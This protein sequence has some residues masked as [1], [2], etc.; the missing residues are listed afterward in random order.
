MFAELDLP[1]QL[2][3]VDLSTLIKGASVR[4]REK[5]S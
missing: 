1:L 4:A 5:E 3:V 2:P